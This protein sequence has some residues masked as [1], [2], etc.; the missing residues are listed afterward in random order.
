[1][2]RQRWHNGKL[3][4]LNSGYGELGYVD[5]TRTEKTED[6]E[7]YHPF[8]SKCFVPGYLRG[9]CFINDEYAVVGRSQDR[10]ERTFQGLPLG[11]KLKKNNIDSRCGLSVINLKTFDVVH[12]LSLEA[13]ITE[14]YDVV[15]VPNVTRPMLEVNQPM[16][17]SQLFD[18]KDIE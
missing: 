9:L 18:F 12:E 11:E 17:L 1:L 15:N 16:A 7:E 14:I 3:W 2:G 8:V 5:F 10:H 13:P 4:V 6:G